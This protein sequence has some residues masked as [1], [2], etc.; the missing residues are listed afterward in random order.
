MAINQ[1]ALQYKGAL[2]VAL[3]LQSVHVITNVVS[4]R[5]PSR[6]SVRDTTLYDKVCQ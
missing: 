1:L 2:V 3:Q 4:S 6:R 5:I